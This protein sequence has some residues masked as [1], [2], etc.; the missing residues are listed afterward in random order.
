MHTLKKSLFLCGAAALLA[1]SCEKEPPVLVVD[2]NPYHKILFYNVENLF[3]TVDQ[4]GVS[5]EE[6]T[7]VA[8][9]NWNGE[10][11]FDKLN[12]IARVI[13]DTGANE[14]PAL[15]G[16][17]EVEN[18]DVLELLIATTPLR[19]AGYEIIHKESPDYRGIDVALL[20]NRNLFHLNAYRAYPVWFP[21]DEAYSTREVLYVK[22]ELED[23]GPVHVFVNHWPSRSSG[24]VETRPKR[25][26]VAE[27]IRSKVDSIFETDPQ[28]RI[29]ITGDFNDEPKDL[30]V[31]S[32]LSGL[33]SFST[34]EPKQLYALS[35]Y[36]QDSSPIG[37]YKYKGNWNFLD[38][39]VLSSAWLDTSQAVYCQPAD[40]EVVQFEYLLTEDKTY[41]G[42]QPY[43]TYLGNYFNGGY[44]DHLPVALKLRYKDP[45]E[46]AQK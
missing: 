45:S 8:E 24:E 44:S 6:F 26:F 33:T 27:M 16:L 37:T 23:I 17:C 19:E 11:L 42:K 30:S 12:K 20:Y 39:F 3:D 4:P 32:G 18:R 40:L 2:Q 43:R 15:V 1:G 13:E 38:Q 36:L 34:P 28:A 25:I 14:W 9:K 21:F 29:V 22:G 41:M 10:K 5:D 35:R 7:P 46:P 31:T